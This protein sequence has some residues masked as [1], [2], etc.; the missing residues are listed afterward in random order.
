M[1]LTYKIL[2]FED[3]DSVIENLQPLI[4]DILDDLGFKLSVT[5]KKG[6]KDDLSEVLEQ[7]DW[8]LILMDFMLKEDTPT[9]DQ[10]IS[11]IRNNQLITEI[12][13][14]SEKK[15]EFIAALR[16][17]SQESVFLEGVFYADNREA[18]PAKL[19]TIIDLTLK[20][21]QDINNIRGLVIA[22]TI[23]LENKVENSLIKFFGTDEKGKVFEKILDP[24]FGVLDTK[25][26][27]D[28]LNKVCK[29][30][31]QTFDKKIQETPKEDIE[32]R[33]KIQESIDRLNL[34]YEEVV[35][36]YDEVIK[37]RNILAHTNPS[38]DKKNVL[39]S[40]L[41]KNGEEIEV[42]D[43]W[44]LL[45]RKNLSKHSE[46]LDQLFSTL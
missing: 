36:L 35:K 14:Y 39:I 24:Q 22:Q 1:Y 18:L 13:F 38:P 29:I 19:K 15:D 45:T 16:G 4:E 27:C 8:D 26:K 2:W 21:Q 10:L 32:T 31:K 23:C 28:L 11:R 41:G 42:N 5:V 34:I 12:I 17:I 7:D 33:K 30:K 9:G 44:C 40:T 20:K 37:I 3:S 25:K 6:I 43:E 46:N